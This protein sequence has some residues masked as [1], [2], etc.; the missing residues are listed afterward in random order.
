MIGIL[1]GLFARENLG[2]ISFAG[3]GAVALLLFYEHSLV[4]PSD[5][6]RVNTAFFTING[7]ISILLCVTTAIDILWN[8]LG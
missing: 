7:W 2:T 6:S 3:L 5:L 4:R 1:A 8:R